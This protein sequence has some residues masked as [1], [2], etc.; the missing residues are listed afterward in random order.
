MLQYSVYNIVK[1]ILEA[2][3][4]KFIDIREVLPISEDAMDKLLK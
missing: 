2:L 3:D 1:I 4:N